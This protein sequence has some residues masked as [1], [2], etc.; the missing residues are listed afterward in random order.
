MGSY[1]ELYAVGGDFFYGGER[2][3]F[4]HRLGETLFFL[5]GSVIRACVVGRQL[6]RGRNGGFS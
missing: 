6:C 1:S 5:L 2:D 3:V 4:S